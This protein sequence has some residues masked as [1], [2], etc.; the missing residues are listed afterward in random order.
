MFR[1]LNP[2]IR[3]FR[4]LTRRSRLAHWLA[5]TAAAAMVAAS[6]SS[7]VG[8]AQAQADRFRPLVTVSV[9]TRAVTTGRAITAADIKRRS[10]PRALLP[11]S[12]PIA[13]PVGRVALADLVPGDVV[14]AARVAPD[15]LRGSRA[16][17][18]RG[19]KALAVERGI[20][21][22]MV[23]PGDRVD[24]VATFD[25]GVAGDGDPTFAVA[26]RALVIDVGDDSVTV[27]V[28]ADEAP[29]VAYALAVGTVALVLTGS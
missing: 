25:P 9:M 14:V 10:W 28:T 4:A 1:Q 21:T 2:W 6:V 22:P 5:A 3:Y 20:A 29:R 15:G 12:A 17:L 26:R 18:P 11:A 8:G 23:R 27:A 16:L 19:R 13:D 24:V 7:A